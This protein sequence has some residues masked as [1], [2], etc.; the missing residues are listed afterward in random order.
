M[1][2]FLVDLREMRRAEG[3]STITQQLARN[4]WLNANKTVSRKIAELLITVHLE[5]KLT[6]QQIFEYY[7]NQVDLGRRGSAIRGFGEA[8]QA[9]FGKNISELTLPEAATLAG[10]IQLPS[11]RNPV[12][13]PDRAKQRRNVV[14]KMMRENGYISQEQNDKAA[15]APLVIAKQGMESSDAPY[16]VDL[17]NQQLLDDFQDRDF[18]DTGYRVYTTIDMDLQR[19]AMEAVAQGYKEVEAL[20]MKRHKKGT[21]LVLPQVALVAL[22]PHTGEVKALVGGTNYGNSQL[23]HAVAKRPSGSVFKPFVYAAALNTGFDSSNGNIITQSTVFPDEPR[24][25]YYQG[26]PYEP[27]NY[28][29]QFYGEVTL[30]TALAKSLNVP[31]IEVAET[32]GYKEERWPILRTGRG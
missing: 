21:P 23:N 6:K 1:K 18:N 13:W 25:F 27:S 30:R 8:A 31:T 9:Y 32:V 11:Y 15:A 10:L 4:I 22:D 16:F 5:R 3:A 14:L 12:R 19:D 7:A 20:V 2:A 17:V 29:N 24:T 26:K 28:E